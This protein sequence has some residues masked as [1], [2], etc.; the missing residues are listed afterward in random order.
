[1][2]WHPEWMPLQDASE[3]LFTAFVNAAK[4]E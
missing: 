1:V 2:Q 4:K 3:K